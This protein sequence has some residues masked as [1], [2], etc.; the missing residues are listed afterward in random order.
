MTEE[1]KNSGWKPTNLTSVFPL[2]TSVLSPDGTTMTALIQILIQMLRLLGFLPPPKNTVSPHLSGGEDVV[3]E[4]EDDH[5]FGD[6]F[7]NALG[8]LR[9]Q[10]RPV[11]QPKRLE[12]RY[13]LVFRY[14]VSV[15]DVI[16]VESPFLKVTRETRQLLW[17]VWQ[18][19]QRTLTKGEGSVQWTSS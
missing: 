6:D 1:Q 7:G 12:R 8:L 18:Q 19:R 5:I 10:L 13:R 11:L 17:T 3:D 4:S 15:T 2:R 16:D 14:V 9:G